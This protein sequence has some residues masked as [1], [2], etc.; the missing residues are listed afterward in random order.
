MKRHFLTK[1]TA[2]GNKA[3][4]LL[5]EGHSALV[6]GRTS[7]G[8]FIKLP[9]D[10]IVYLTH[11]RFR[12]PLTINLGGEIHTLDG[13]ENEMLVT[14]GEGELLIPDIDLRIQVTPSERWC[15]PVP[16][17]RVRSVNER[18]ET[19]NTF[20]A[21]ILT[22]IGEDDFPEVSLWLRALVRGEEI[23]D[24][25]L[26]SLLHLQKLTRE[27]EFSEVEEVCHKLLGRGE[28]LTPA[29]DDLLL[30]WLLSLN[31]WR[32]ILLP[33]IDLQP[34]NEAIVTAAYEKTTTISANLMECVA[35]GEGDERL[36]AVVDAIL[37]EVGEQKNLIKDLLS[38]GSSSGLYAF[39]GMGAAIG[40][41]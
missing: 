2:I 5:Q 36:L 15:A 6:V 3:Y 11:E 16:K 33:D 29:G 32:Q 31:R 21:E 9:P 1:I 10:R 17:A 4:D 26:N 28:G 18:F 13:I 30:G 12:G 25:K 14:M 41:R 22:I 40:S 20:A 19:L 35:K 37:Y 39:C 7:T 8:A 38:W 24:S 34:L 27:G 23:P